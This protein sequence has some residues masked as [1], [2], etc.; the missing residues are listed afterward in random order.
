MK[1]R[2]PRYQSGAAIRVKSRHEISALLD[3]L[4]RT[5]GCRFMPAMSRFCDQ[6]IRIVKAVS[7]IYDEHRAEMCGTRAPL[8]ILEGALCDGDG[9]E[10]DVRC[11]RSCYFLWHE[12]WLDTIS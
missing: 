5:D 4:G 3:E 2:R 12:D 10:F 11:D 1:R 9:A 8:Y 6:Q 7:T